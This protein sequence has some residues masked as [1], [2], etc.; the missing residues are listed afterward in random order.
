[1]NR[2]IIVTPELHPNRHPRLTELNTRIADFDYH[3]HLR[4]PNHML[5]SSE[6]MRE[7]QLLKDKAVLD[8]DGWSW[9]FDDAMTT[10]PTATGAPNGQTRRQYTLTEKMGKACFR[11]MFENLEEALYGNLP[12]L[13]RWSRDHPDNLDASGL[14]KPFT[15]RWAGFIEAV[16]GGPKQAPHRDVFLGNS[17]IGY[18]C[19]VGVEPA[20]ERIHRGSIVDCS[21]FGLP[22]PYTEIP[23]DLELGDVVAFVNT[24]IHNG[25]RCSETAE[26]SRIIFLFARSTDTELDYDT[27]VTLMP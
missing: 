4:A 17:D 15:L 23:F 5:P 21:A 9:I 12:V 10:H 7:L 6:F 16:V 14:R 19:A 22:D 8:P 24:V 26:T 27:Y 20:Q 25:G 18:T 3:H 1:M 2:R 13:H 11:R